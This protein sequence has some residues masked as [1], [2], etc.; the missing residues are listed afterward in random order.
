[1]GY[2]T[3][4]CPSGS[5]VVSVAYH[6]E[7]GNTLLGTI[8]ILSQIKVRSLEPRSAALESKLRRWLT[9]RTALN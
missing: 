5:E 4:R 8:Q 1:M 3:P 9:R 7:P 2:G 6:T